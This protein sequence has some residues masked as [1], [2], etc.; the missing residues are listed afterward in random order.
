MKSEY[1][2]ENRYVLIED[3]A[4]EDFSEV[5]Q[6]DINSTTLS[7]PRNAVFNSFLSDN[8]NQYAATTTSHSKG[9]ILLIKNKKLLTTSLSTIWDNT[10]GCAE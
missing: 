7:R 8:I 6:A 1:Y 5:P 9:L 2:G 4:L 3:I 10:D